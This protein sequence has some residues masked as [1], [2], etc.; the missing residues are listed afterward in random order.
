MNTDEETFVL[1]DDCQGIIWR[2][3]EGWWCCLRW[4]TGLGDTDCNGPYPSLIQ[5]R[6]ALRV[7]YRLW[8]NV[9]G[10]AK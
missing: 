1:D 6:I 8:M 7:F 5:A 9:L 10:K 2:E 3:G 4:S